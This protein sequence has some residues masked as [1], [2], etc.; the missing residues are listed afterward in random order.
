MQKLPDNAEHSYKCARCGHV[1]AAEGQKQAA[2]PQCGF[3]CSPESC[4]VIGASNEGY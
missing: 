1:F 4:R 2:C 3:V